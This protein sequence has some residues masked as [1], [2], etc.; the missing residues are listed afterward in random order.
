MTANALRIVAL[1][2]LLASFV[3]GY[4]SFELANR[5]RDERTD[6]G[7]RASTGSAPRRTREALDPANYRAEAR[8]Q[9]ERLRA[10]RALQGRLLLGAV[11]LGV[12][13]LFID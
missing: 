3:V 6:R 11:A 1:V 2:C 4:L 12:I 8:P 9:V 10:R 13:S 5:L 7:A